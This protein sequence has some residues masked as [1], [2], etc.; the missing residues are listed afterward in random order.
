MERGRIKSLAHILH[1]LH[2]PKN[3]IFTLEKD[4]I[5][6]TYMVN[7]PKNGDIVFVR[8]LT[9]KDNSDFHHYTYIGLLIDEPYLSFKAKK[10]QNWGLDTDKVSV[11]VYLMNTLV[12]NLLRNPKFEE[13][14]PHFYHEGKCS[15]CGK[16]LTV[17]ASIERGMGA[18]CAKEL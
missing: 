18:I 13:S 10:Q 16:K 7:K 6:R 1:F 14:L 3:A 8:L 12:D 9:G 2:S 4:D 17:P 15:K 5:H 11:S